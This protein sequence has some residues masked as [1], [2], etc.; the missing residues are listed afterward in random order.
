MASVRFRFRIRIRISGNV[1]GFLQMIW[2][3][4]NDFIKTVFQVMSIQ[5]NQFKKTIFTK[6]LIYS[7]IKL[8]RRIKFVCFRFSSKHK[9]LLLSQKKLF[10][11]KQIQE[12]KMEKHDNNKSAVCLINVSHIFSI[13]S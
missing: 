11:Y 8:K 5:S 7:V 1:K 4:L 13:D 9:Q 2:S 10:N 12:N 6:Q 3:R